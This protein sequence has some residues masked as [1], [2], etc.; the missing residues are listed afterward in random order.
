MWD[1]MRSSS[2]ISTVL[3]GFA[4]ASL[5]ACGSGGNEGFAGATQNPTNDS[6]D[7]SAQAPAQNGGNGAQPPA[8]PAIPRELPWE[9]VSDEGETYLPNVFY[10]EASE[11]QQVMPVALDGHVQIDRLVYPTLGN[12]NLY[13]KSDA[14][15]SFMM[16]LRIE[17]G[18]F[19]HLGP[20]MSKVAPDGRLHEL[21]LHQDGLNMLTALLIPRSARDSATESTA[22]VPTT[23]GVIRLT[24]TKILVNPIDADMPSAFKSRLTLRL[25]FDKTAMAQVPAALYDVRFEVLKNG[26]L[27]SMPGQAAGVYEYQYNGLRVFDTASDEYQVV[28]VTDTQFSVGDL[29]GS[30]TADKL[31]QFV[32]YVNTSTDANVQKAAFITF[33]GDLHNGG[34]P[35]SLR[36]RTVANTYNNE[37]KGIVSA[38]KELTLPIFLTIG[39]HDGYVSTGQVP[40]AVQTLDEVTF[41]S[42]KKVT[43]DANPKAWPDYSW[44]NFSAYIDKTNKPGSVGGVHLDITSGSFTKAPGQTFTDSWKEVAIGD[45]N[46]ILYDGFY[47][48]QKTYG[49][50]FAS[51]KFGKNRY[52]NMNSY[53]IRQH[54]R[55]GWGMYTVNY[56]GNISPFQMQWI[57]REI[58][59]SKDASDDVV[60]LAHHD[61]RG[62]HHNKDYGYYFSN[63]EFS[64]IYQSAIN[65]VIAEPLN[66]FLC[67]LPSW[68][69]NMDTTQVCT[70]DGLQEWMAPDRE[71]DCKA[72]ERGAD[73][74]C[75]A[76]LFDPSL[77]TTAAHYYFSAFELI[78]RLSNNPQIRT[79]VLGHTHYNSLEMMQAGDKMLPDTLPMSAQDQATYAALEVQNPVRAASIAN[80]GSASDYDPSMVSQDAVKQ[81]IQQLA[82]IYN[83]AAATKAHQ[84]AGDKREIAVLRL[85][86]NADLTS[87]KFGSDTML[88]FAVLTISAKSD[89]R[90]Y[91]TPQINKV[92]YFINQGSDN[93]GEVK[94]VD[95][96]RTQHVDARSTTNNPVFTM[97]N[98]GP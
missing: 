44:D 27:F 47:Q 66:S 82:D 36:E 9:I 14:N 5:V 58:A 76:K 35:G 26:A 87:Q 7:P 90:A 17:E 71:F 38:L 98:G 20:D 56:G 88:G 55:S 49:P 48:W 37:A 8:A 85:T 52:V 24:P 34:S 11:N 96:D 15:D 63:I 81:G 25:V 72:S 97:F 4:I 86:S 59:K 77:G 93:F 57:D 28:N 64:S 69:T 13:V 45:R 73:G 74:K 75:D 16:V 42:L 1:T 68:A 6:N 79:L 3:G 12:P 62:G 83:G 67:K 2:W 19:A 10:A 91:A 50:T 23:N 60:M 46:M 22:A 39:N 80:Q 33:N 43:D 78:E 89:T 92:L 21:T 41:D 31:N 53:E 29:Y 30:K 95:I 40:G 32:Y 18:A 70:H 65:Y 54:H 61:S 51:W 84:V 94:S